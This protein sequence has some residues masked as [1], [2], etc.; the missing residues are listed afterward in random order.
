MSGYPQDPKQMQSAYSSQQNMMSSMIPQQGY[1]SIPQSQ[2]QQQAQ[3]RI[4]QHY[5]QSGHQMYGTPPQQTPTPQAYSAY[6][7]QHQSSRTATAQHPAYGHTQLDQTGYGHLGNQGPVGLPPIPI[8]QTQSHLGQSAQSHQQQQQQQQQ[9]QLHQLQHPSMNPVAQPPVLGSTHGTQQQQQAQSQQ[10]HLTSQAQHA[11]S[12]MLHSAGAPQHQSSMSTQQ[13]S[14][15]SHQIPQG[16]NSAPMPHQMSHSMMPNYANQLTGS[17]ATA[18]P[19][20]PT[21]LPNSKQ[22]PATQQQQHGSSP[23]YRAPF[24]QL[25]PQMSPRPQMSPH[26]HPQMSP[27][28]VMSPAKPPPQQTQNVQQ[29]TNNQSPHPHIPSS[30]S[31]SQSALPSIQP[32]GKSSIAPSNTLQA[33][34]QMVMPSANS[35]SI[36]YNQTSYRQQ[37]LP[38]MPN[39]PLSPLGQHVMSPQHQQWPTHRSQMNGS[40]HLGMIPQNQMQISQQI[41]QN[42][43]SQ[44]MSQMPDLMSSSQQQSMQVIPSQQQ[45]QQQQQQQAQHQQP[46]YSSYED[47][48]QQPQQKPLDSIHKPYENLTPSIPSQQQ[49]Q[50]QQNQQQQQQQQQ[51]LGNNTINQLLSPTH[52]QLDQ[53]QQEQ[54]ASMQV[55]QSS[56]STLESTDQSS[57]LNLLDSYSNSATVNTSNMS[58]T[59]QKSSIDDSLL[60]QTTN[61]NSQSSQISENAN[62]MMQT[63]SFGND[64]I[65]DENANQQSMDVPFLDS[66]D[67]AND[68][69][70]KNSD[71]DDEQD[72]QL[73]QD[74]NDKIESLDFEFGAEIQKP[75]SADSTMINETDKQITNE[76]TNVIPDITKTV[77]DIF[78]LF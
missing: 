49:Q 32:S 57:D 53:Q 45:Q 37:A 65:Q 73:Q 40:S 66:H 38:S 59:A 58:S 71:N 1:A 54:Y 78:I 3:Q 50:Q 8:Q 63:N 17:T 20:G 36:D 14:Q 75:K 34:E 39:N 12:S 23:Q 48:N 51:Q 47:L 7:V 5:P 11:A 72:A 46:A 61:E 60:S 28:P 70:Q 2:H 41:S 55:N 74:V 62:S 22:A 76:M 68:D 25:S 21:Y 10:S 27:R 16:H 33:L 6:G 44:M 9:Q 26:P 24:P 18:P 29:T 56:L 64:P 77:R 69:F 67:K 42:P 15:Q 13:S 52:A 31:R 35:A 30:S 43:S 19:Q 4:S